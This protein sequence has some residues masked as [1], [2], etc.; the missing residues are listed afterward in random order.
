[1][2]NSTANAPAI[3]ERPGRETVHCWSK[4]RS[5]VDYKNIIKSNFMW[6]TTTDLH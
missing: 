6:V 4:V 3:I 2:S 1:M 5:R